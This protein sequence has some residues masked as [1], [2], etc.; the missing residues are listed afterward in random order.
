MEGRKIVSEYF[1]SGCCQPRPGMLHCN[2]L[3]H[4]TVLHVWSLPRS[5]PLYRP[6][7]ESGRL[8][9]LSRPDAMKT[10][11]RGA[12]RDASTRVHN[13]SAWSF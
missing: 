1:D 11:L 7:I 5:Y 2:R 9:N 13:S 12:F 10:C 3:E 8:G 4:H 6:D